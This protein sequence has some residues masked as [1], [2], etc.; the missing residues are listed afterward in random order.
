MQS[1]SKC[2]QEKNNKSGLNVE[3]KLIHPS[4]L[5]EYLSSVLATVPNILFSES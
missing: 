3:T 2:I 4:H 5:T 1:V